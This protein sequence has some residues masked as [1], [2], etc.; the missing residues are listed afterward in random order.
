MALR[1]GLEIAVILSRSQRCT[2]DEQLAIDQPE[3]ADV[4]HGTRSDVLRWLP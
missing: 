2:I 3:D 4:G 1:M